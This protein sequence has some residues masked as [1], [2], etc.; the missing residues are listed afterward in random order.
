MNQTFGYAINQVT[1]VFNALNFTN[2]QTFS[3]AI[4]YGL[5]ALA[6]GLVSAFL[7]S[8]TKQ[9]SSA[10]RIFRFMGWAGSLVVLIVSIGLPEQGAYQL[11]PMLPFVLPLFAIWFSRDGEENDGIERRGRKKKN[12]EVWAAY[13]TS[14]AFLPLVALVYL[15]ANPVVQD[16]VVQSGQSSERSAIASYIHNHSKA[17]DTIYAW[18]TTATLYQESDRLSASALLTPT[19]YLGINE[20]RTNVIQ[21]IDRSEPKY[22]VVNNQVE[23]TSNMKDLLKENYRL[24]E[25]KYRHF[26]LYQRS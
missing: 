22:I 15:L 19:S 5:L 1:Y 21:Q 20:N 11:L 10:R 4:Y 24:V 9:S 8:F 13:F 7:M 25:K 26:K 23:L 3:N 14:Q 12:K 17:K 16:V 6:F 18:D 2:G